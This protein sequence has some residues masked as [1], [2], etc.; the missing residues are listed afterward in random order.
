MSFYTGVKFPGVNR[1]ENASEASFSPL[2]AM[3][4][5]SV[6]SWMLTDF[7]TLHDNWQSQT[8]SQFSVALLFLPAAFCVYIPSV[9]SLLPF[10]TGEMWIWEAGLFCSFMWKLYRRVNTQQ[11]S[12]SLPVFV[13]L[14]SWSQTVLQLSM[15]NRCQNLITR[16]CFSLDSLQSSAS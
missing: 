3:P 1:I 7:I 16:N 8:D 2:T 4:T 14:F 13:S 10:L 15:K 11:T 9:W 6:W 12:I 5:A